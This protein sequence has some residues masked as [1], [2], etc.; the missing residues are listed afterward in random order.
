MEKLEPSVDGIIDYIGAM[1]AG[2]STGLKWNEVAKLKSDMMLVRHRW[3]GVDLSALE[4]KCRAVGLDDEDTR[5]VLDLVRKVKAGKRLVPQ[6]GY[7]GFRWN[8]EPEPRAPVYPADSPASE[9]WW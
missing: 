6:N 4:A 5:T 2:Y 8:T 9:E 7:R 1:A 3:I